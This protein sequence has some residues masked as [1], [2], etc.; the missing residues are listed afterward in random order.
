M[1]GIF[2]KKKAATDL[3]LNKEE[4]LITPPDEQEEKADTP[5]P[6]PTEEMQTIPSPPQTPTTPDD[7]GIKVSI[8]FRRVSWQHKLLALC[9]TAVSPVH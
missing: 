1:L 7:D 3:Q 6:S 5:K 4:L 8:M 9:K 2:N